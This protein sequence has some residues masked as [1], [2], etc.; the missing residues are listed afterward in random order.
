[1]TKFGTLLERAGPGNASKNDGFERV[2]APPR[3][4]KGARVVS[5]EL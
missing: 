5:E 2:G 4:R 1:M 3:E